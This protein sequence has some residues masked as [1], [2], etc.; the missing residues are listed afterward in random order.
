MAR[1]LFLINSRDRKYPAVRKS[2][3]NNVSCFFILSESGEDDMANINFDYFTAAEAEQYTFYRI[4]KALFTEGHFQALSCEAKVLYGMMLDRIGLSIRNQWF[5][6]QGR[7][8]IIFTVEDVMKVMG[9][10]SQKAVRLMKELDTVDGIG[11]IEKKRIGLGR[12]NRIYV[13]NFMVRGDGGTDMRTGAHRNPD[14]K[15]AGSSSKKAADAQYNVDAFERKETAPADISGCREQETMEKETLKKTADDPRSAG[16]RENA[17][18]EKTAELEKNNAGS[19]ENWW[20]CGETMP[21]YEDSMEKIAD[22]QAENWWDTAMD[23]CLDG[24]GR[25]QDAGN[26]Q[27]GMEIEAVNPVMGINVESVDNVGTYIENQNS[28]HSAYFYGE[29]AAPGKNCGCPDGCAAPERAAWMPE[30]PAA[31]PAGRKPGNGREKEGVVFADK[32][33]E[34]MVR[35]LLWQEDG[36]G[37]DGGS[38]EQGP[39]AGTGQGFPEPQGMECEK[40]DSVIVDAKAPE[41]WNA[42]RN[43]TEYSNTEYIKTENSEKEINENDFSDSYQSYQSHQS[44]LSGRQFQAACHGQDGCD[45][46]MPGNRETDSIEGKMDAYREAIREN[47]SYSCFNS[48]ETGDVDE[49]VELMVDAMMVPDRHTIRV[50]GIEKPASVVKSRF[51]KLV[52]SHIEYVVECL[53]K[54]TGK[55]WNIK[56][57]LL[58]ALYNSSLTISNYYRAEVNHDLYGCGC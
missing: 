18:L 34:A 35:G 40:Q 16:C 42:K 37:T 41:S 23:A 51:M 31:R 6:S 1:L 9:C 45:T 30:T 57:Y 33:I 47:I 58:T 24:S 55:I 52:H 13:K 50:A 38:Q 21:G 8:Y 15:A 29:T 3:W 43:D 22:A 26:V 56:A 44:N 10:Q 32:T 7:A 27:G 11:L 19:E 28:A 46:D 36:A 39:Q 2:R 4:P 17:A 49:L 54:H 48:S 20:M 14:Q 53:Q 25:Q 5:D 12:P